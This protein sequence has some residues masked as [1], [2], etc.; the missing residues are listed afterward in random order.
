MVALTENPMGDP[1]GDLENILLYVKKQH[2]S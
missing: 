1:K 2:F